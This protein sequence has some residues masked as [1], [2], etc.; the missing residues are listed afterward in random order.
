LERRRPLKITLSSGD[1]PTI[2]L[3]PYIPVNIR[4]Q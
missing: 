2:D 3:T 4:D 1:G